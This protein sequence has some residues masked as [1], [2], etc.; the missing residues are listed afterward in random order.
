MYQLAVLLHSHMLELVDR[1][2]TT[3]TDQPERGSETIEKIVW[4]VAV[5]AIVALAVAAITA[6][7]NRTAGKLG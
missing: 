6:F 2:H 5:L 7:V 4:A 3:L 1:A